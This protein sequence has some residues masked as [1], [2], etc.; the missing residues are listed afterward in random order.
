[1]L[2]RSNAPAQGSSALDR[3]ILGTAAHALLERWDFVVEPPI[4]EVAREFFPSANLKTLCIHELSTII[5]RLQ[6]SSLWPQLSASTNA[7]RELPFLFEIG[8]VFLNGVIDALL[9]ANTLVDYKL[10]SPAAGRLERHETQLRI[11]AAA[12]R[13]ETGRS[14]QRAVLYY[15]NSGQLIDVDVRPVILDETLQHANAALRAHF[16]PAPDAGAARGG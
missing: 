6:Q 2:F 4:A 16:A 13:A 11:Y 10:G 5:E 3:R 12:I 15:M 8:G 14:P 7:R 1:M 9:D